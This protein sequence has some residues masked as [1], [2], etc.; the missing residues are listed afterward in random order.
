MSRLI[1]S[2]KRRMAIPVQCLLLTIAACATLSAESCGKARIYAEQNH[3]P[4][5]VGV[6][7][8]V[9]GNEL[10]ATISG[11][12]PQVMRIPYSELS[13]LEFERSAHRRWKTGVIIS[14]S[15]SYHKGKKH[16]FAVIQGENETVFQLSK[17]TYSRIPGAV[18]SKSGL[19]GEDDSESGVTRALPP[20][21]I[22]SP[23]LA[24]LHLVDGESP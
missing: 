18:E 10:V 5:L 19:E 9:Q 7:I 22:S 17:S 16:W 13:E 23:S 3:K 4:K 21:R 12:D 24:G 6:S 20:C 8:D 14:L 2:H 11:I 1:D 15:S